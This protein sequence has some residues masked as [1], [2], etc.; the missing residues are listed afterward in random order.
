[1]VLLI[2]ELRRYWWTIAKVENKFNDA[3]WYNV[4]FLKGRQTI[5]LPNGMDGRFDIRTLRDIKAAVHLVSIL[6]IYFNCFTNLPTSRILMNLNGLDVIAV[7][8]FSILF[9][10]VDQLSESLKLSERFP[11]RLSRSYMTTAKCNVYVLKPCLSNRQR[12]WSGFG[13]ALESDPFQHKNVQRRIF[14]QPL[15]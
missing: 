1:M 7:K 14:S 6:N 13:Q 15:W 8:L 5:N 4:F 10:C 9:T 12:N 3:F 11:R 2:A